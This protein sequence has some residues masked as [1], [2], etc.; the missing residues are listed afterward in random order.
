MNRSSEF[1]N[2]EIDKNL[3]AVLIQLHYQIR[4]LSEFGT[5]VLRWDLEKQRGGDALVPPMLFLRSQIEIIESISILIKDSL[6]D[7][8]NALLRSI[9]E[10]T[11]YLEYL[12]QE[13]TERRSLSF[14]V[15]IDIE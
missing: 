12:L 10:T 3:Q 4:K 1:L 7:P 11:L 13:D 8:C 9:I 5:E 15:G 2:R 6:A 14:I